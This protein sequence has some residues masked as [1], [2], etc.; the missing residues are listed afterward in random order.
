M[1]LMLPPAENQPIDPVIAIGLILLA[2][3]MS[4]G[5]LFAILVAAGATVAR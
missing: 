4:T 1:A 5:I 2:C 3:I